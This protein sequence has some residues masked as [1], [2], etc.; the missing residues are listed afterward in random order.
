MNE[1]TIEALKDAISFF[2]WFTKSLSNSEE[3]SEQELEKLKK[4]EEEKEALIKLRRELIFENEK[5]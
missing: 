5:K 2:E 4:Y 3:M 1:I